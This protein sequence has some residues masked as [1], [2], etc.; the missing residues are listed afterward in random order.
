MCF[1]YK[2]QLFYICFYLPNLPLIPRTSYLHLFWRITSSIYSQYQNSCNGWAVDTARRQALTQE[3]CCLILEDGEAPAYKLRLSD[4]SDSSQ[5]VFQHIER[6]AKASCRRIH[7]QFGCVFLKDGSIH[8]SGTWNN[9]VALHCDLFVYVQELVP[10]EI[11]F[12]S[13]RI[14]S[15]KARAVYKTKTCGAW[16][17]VLI[18]VKDTRVICTNK[19]KQEN[20]GWN[21]IN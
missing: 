21:M 7:L 5:F 6:V 8:G 12:L 11:C 3:V 20:L 16:L 2:E 1:W 10:S 17:T 9:D 13:V 15:N 4:C 18:N 14:C 19:I